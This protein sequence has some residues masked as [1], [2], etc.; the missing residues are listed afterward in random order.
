MHILRT[1]DIKDRDSLKFGFK[2]KIGKMNI[3]KAL[4]TI[5]ELLDEKAATRSR[6]EG[7]T[8]IANRIIDG[9]SSNTVYLTLRDTAQL[10]DFARVHEPDWFFKE[11]FGDYVLYEEDIAELVDVEN[12][13]DKIFGAN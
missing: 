6:L 11:L 1:F 3:T 5:V 9:I 13:L 10:T 8:S 2:D 7:K 4:Y 12:A